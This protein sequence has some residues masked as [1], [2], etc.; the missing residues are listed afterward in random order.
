M[1]AHA[2]QEQTIS[3]ENKEQKALFSKKYFCGMIESKLKVYEPALRSVHQILP[4]QY[5]TSGKYMPT[6]VVPKCLIDHFVYTRKTLQE[7]C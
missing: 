4:P 2:A 5:S 6:F 7:L 1:V 3:E